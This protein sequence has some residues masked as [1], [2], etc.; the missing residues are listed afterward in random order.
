MIFQKRKVIVHFHF[1]KNAG[2]T[3]DYILRRNFP[4]GFFS[5]DKQ[6]PSA[7]IPPEDGI[8]FIQ[9]NR[10]L[11]V[12]TSHQLLYPLPEHKNLL[13]YS[14]F[15]L[16]HPID[17]IYSAY[18]FNRK[19]NDWPKDSVEKQL[20]FKDY[21]IWRIDTNGK[22]FRDFHVHRLTKK[23]NNFNLTEKERIDAAKEILQSS[24]FF[25][26][27]ERFDDSLTLMRDYLCQDFPKID[28][29]YTIQNRSSKIDSLDERLVTI[30]EQLGIEL[31]EKL[32][33]INCLDM[34]LYDYALIIFDQRMNKVTGVQNTGKME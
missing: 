18:Q 25:G 34:E 30:R 8:E 11:Q 6:I 4:K 17:R 22:G 29:A 13:I 24:D 16:R 21:I 27:V 19:R 26:I 33:A 2:T 28:Y 5:L 15:F 31:Y 7:I 32:L 1:F 20:S 14:I 12:L 3:I 10:T 9:K 23:I